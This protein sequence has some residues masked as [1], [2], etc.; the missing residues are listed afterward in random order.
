MNAAS[1][2]T[3]IDGSIEPA[4]ARRISIFQEFKDDP[5]SGKSSQKFEISSELY[6][7]IIA[8]NVDVHIKDAPLYDVYHGELFNWY[9][10]RR[11]VRDSGNRPAAY[12]WEKSFGCRLRDR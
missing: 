5:M 7:K 10:Q 4:F 8:G 6:R 3:F 12:E 1:D 2:E 11:I 9:E